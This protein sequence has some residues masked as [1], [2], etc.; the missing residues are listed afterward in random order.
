MIQTAW[1]RDALGQLEEGVRWIDLVEIL[2]G[3][4]EN[5]PSLEPDENVF[6]EGRS[7][8]IFGAFSRQD[9]CVDL[10]ANKKMVPFRPDGCAP[11]DKRLTEYSRAQTSLDDRAFACDSFDY[12]CMLPTTDIDA[13]V[14]TLRG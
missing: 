3:D 2:R 8:S 11:P 10:G 13:M 1:R 6:L 9:N 14:A 7:E 4:T 12:V 5:D